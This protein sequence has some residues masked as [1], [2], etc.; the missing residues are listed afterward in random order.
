[1]AHVS[2]RISSPSGHVAVLK[3]DLETGFMEAEARMPVRATTHVHGADKQ[4][5]AVFVADL[6]REFHE[7]LTAVP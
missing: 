1:M 7:I 5:H 4:L 3:V 6:A 2:G